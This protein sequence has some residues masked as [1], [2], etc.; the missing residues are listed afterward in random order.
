MMQQVYREG[1]VYTLEDDAE[2]SFC[3]KCGQINSPEDVCTEFLNVSGEV[4]EL[5]VHKEC[6]EGA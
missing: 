1:T 6:Q 3:F 5:E 4:W 2:P